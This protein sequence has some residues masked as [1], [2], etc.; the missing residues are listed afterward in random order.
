MVRDGA[1]TPEDHMFNMLFKTDPLTHV[2]PAGHLIQHNKNKITFL[3]YTVPLKVWSFSV[4]TPRI[5]LKNT[6]LRSLF[7]VSDTFEEVNDLCV[8]KSRYNNGRWF[9]EI[10]NT[11]RVV[12]S[13]VRPFAPFPALTFITWSGWFHVYTSSF[14]VAAIASQV[15]LPYATRSRLK[16]ERRGERA[17]RADSTEV[18]LDK[19]RVLRCSKSRFVHMPSRKRSRKQPQRGSSSKRLVSVN[20]KTFI[21]KSFSHRYLPRASLL[22]CVVPDTSATNP[23]PAFTTHSFQRAEEVG[24]SLSETK[25]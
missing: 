17:N 22:P 14:R 24:G 11:S 6:P 7:P 3:S 5:P 16:D 9:A 12:L 15:L 18:I 1:T 19:S 8:L 23:C 25:I 21:K 4:I 2:T 20:S 10:G 13:T